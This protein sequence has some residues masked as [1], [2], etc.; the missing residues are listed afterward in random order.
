MDK[1]LIHKKQID[2][3]TSIEF[4]YNDVSIWQDGALVVLTKEEVLKI[5]KLIEW[6]R[7]DTEFYK[8]RGK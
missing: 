3:I 5:A 1:R 8:K 6:E 7:H 2:A 4:S